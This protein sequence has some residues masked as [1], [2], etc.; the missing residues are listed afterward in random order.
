MA[1]ICKVF[2]PAISTFEA[3]PTPPTTAGPPNCSR[4]PR[5]PLPPISSYRGPRA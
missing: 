5:C 4:C 3:P 2:L 1:L